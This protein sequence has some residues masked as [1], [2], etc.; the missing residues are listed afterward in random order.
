VHAPPPALSAA[1]AAVP[2]SLATTER[3]PQAAGW[4]AGEVEWLSFDVATQRARAD[5][6][7]ICLVVY[8]SWCPH[9][10]NF[11]HVF[12]DPR[13]VE[14]AKRFRMVRVDADQEPAIAGR[15][16]PDG[17]YIPR[18]FFLSSD[19][20]LDDAIHLERAKYQYFYDE[21]NPAALVAA[22]DSALQKR[23]R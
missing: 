15:F 14:R 16:V 22:M 1:A 7:P 4:N 18:T 13:V 20:T 8:T 17:A 9:C 10:R 23:A 5:Q 12:E 19:G 11:S 21:R 6:S 3:T 2:S